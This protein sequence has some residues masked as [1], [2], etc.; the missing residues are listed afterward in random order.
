MVEMRSGGYE[1][2]KEFVRFYFNHGCE[3]RL[4]EVTY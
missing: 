3:E 2:R 4:C 1:E